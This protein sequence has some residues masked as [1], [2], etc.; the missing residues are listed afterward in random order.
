[1]PNAKIE[2]KIGGLH[3]SCEA[4]QEWVTTQ[5]DKII[6]K[7]DVLG[8]LEEKHDA[9]HDPH[10]PAP[11]PGQVPTLPNFLIAKNATTNQVRRFL[12]TAGWLHL[13]GK[14]VSTKEVAAALKEN[15]QTKLSNPS[16]C[17]NQNVGKGFCE[18]DGSGFFITN[19]GLN[20]LGLKSP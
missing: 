3:F 6:A 12:A 17:L 8:K 1:M 15:H 18:K 16:E 5:L 10:I 11:K 13:K 20:E 2:I 4:E 7:A 14:T 9:P 19:E